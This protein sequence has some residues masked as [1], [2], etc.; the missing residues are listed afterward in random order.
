ML[1]SL[2]AKL[3][4]T[5][6]ELEMLLDQIYI[7]GSCGWKNLFFRPAGTTYYSK[8]YGYD[9]EAEESLYIIQWEGSPEYDSGYPSDVFSNLEE[10]A[11][12]FN[13]IAE[14]HTRR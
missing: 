7:H 9:V 4:S 12:A 11:K 3:S 2:F 6:K 8:P 10:A 13:K 5:D 14:K 1:L